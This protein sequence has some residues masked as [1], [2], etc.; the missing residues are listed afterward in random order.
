MSLKFQRHYPMILL[1]LAILA[2]LT[3]AIGDLPIIAYSGF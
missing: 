1:L 3:F 2:F